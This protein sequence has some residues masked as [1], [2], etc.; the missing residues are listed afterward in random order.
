MK[1]VMNDL[2]DLWSLYGSIVDILLQKN[3]DLTPPQQ[4]VKALA[5]I[6]DFYK[7]HQQEVRIFYIPIVVCHDFVSCR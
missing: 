4:N 2:K 3:I 6:L 1:I 7:N 5:D